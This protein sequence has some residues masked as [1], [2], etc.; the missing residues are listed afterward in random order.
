MKVAIFT[1][2]TYGI[3]FLKEII[4]KLI[5]EGYLKG[6]IEF[7]RSYTPSLIKKCHNV[8]IKVKSVIREVDRVIVVIDKEN[9]YN[10]NEEMEIWRHLKNLSSKDKSKISIIATEPCIEEW[11]CISLDFE[12]DKTGADI[13]LKPDRVL[14]RNIG[15][16]KEELAKYAE[17]L[18]IE[19]LLK[20]SESFKKF[21]NALK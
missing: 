6:N 15:Y 5:R 12:F 21:Y 20:Y 3:K 9:V 1:E 4:N 19:K 2:D 13:D 10:Y 16:K 14:E 7:V 8:G 17:K 11:I 18:D